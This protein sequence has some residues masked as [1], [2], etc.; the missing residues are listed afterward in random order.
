[1]RLLLQ[2]FFVRIDRV[3]LSQ[4]ADREVFGVYGA[5]MQLVEY[6]IQAAWLMGVAA[7]PAF[8]FAYMRGCEGQK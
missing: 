6:W 7:G 2:H 5:T 1:M 3:V 8:L 4:M